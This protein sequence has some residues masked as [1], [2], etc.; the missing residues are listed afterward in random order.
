MQQGLE[1]P[2]RLFECFCHIANRCFEDFFT[3]ERPW[4]VMFVI[5]ILRLV[6]VIAFKK[7][8][9]FMFG[10]NGEP[11]MPPERYKQ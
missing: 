8:I 4:T 2:S 7:G 11:H 6:L 5:L 10:I 9:I 3:E 1:V